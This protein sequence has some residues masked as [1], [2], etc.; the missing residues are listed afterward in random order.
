LRSQQRRIELSN[1][2]VQVDSDLLERHLV[3]LRDD[4]LDGRLSSRELP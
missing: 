4:V 3:E 1:R 2:I